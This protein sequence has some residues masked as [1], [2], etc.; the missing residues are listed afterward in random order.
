MTKLSL[1]FKEALTEDKNTK[2]YALRPTIEDEC[3]KTL[4]QYRIPE[5]EL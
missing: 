2:E 4:M 3:W 5:F 1:D